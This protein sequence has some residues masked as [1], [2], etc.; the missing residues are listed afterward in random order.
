[1]AELTILDGPSKGQGFVIQNPITRIGRRPGNDWVLAENSISGTHCEIERIGNGYTIRDLGSTNG[2]SVNGSTI[3]ESAIFRNDVIMLGDLSL[4]LTGDDVPAD[5]DGEA[6]AL[7]RTTIVIQPKTQKMKIP[8]AFKKKTSSTKAWV[9]IITI[10]IFIILL[11]LVK[12]WGSGTH[13]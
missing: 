8:D 6:V 12:L 2:T 9:S 3:K 4:E 11:L 13:L 10:L 5:G 1:M 7:S